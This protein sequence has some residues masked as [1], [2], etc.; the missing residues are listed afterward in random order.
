MLSKVVVAVSLTPE[1]VAAVRDDLDPDHTFQ[2]LTL[3]T[4]TGVFQP[5]ELSK[6][7]ISGLIRQTSN[8]A[9]A[10]PGHKCVSGRVG[11]WAFCV[12]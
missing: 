6:L 12:L 2:Y 7:P 9:S 11:A 5:D 10:V 8:W 1:L 4:V 3:P